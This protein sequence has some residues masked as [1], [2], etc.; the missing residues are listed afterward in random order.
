MISSLSWIR[1]LSLSANLS[2]LALPLR[3][4]RVYG[5]EE[6]EWG[7]WIHVVTFALC[8]LVSKQCSLLA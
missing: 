6:C 3:I 7:L 2:L 1:T 5:G 8:L 4:F